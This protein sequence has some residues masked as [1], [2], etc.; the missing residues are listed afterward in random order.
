MM[1]RRTCLQQ[2]WHDSS[3]CSLDAGFRGWV[4]LLL[5]L[6]MLSST[7]CVK[8]RF[9]VTSFPEGA[10]V[11]VDNQPVGY[12]PVNVPFRYPGTREILL[13]KDGYKPIRIKQ[14]IRTP[15]YLYPPFSFITENFALREIRDQQAFDFQMQ[16]LNQVNDQDLIDR[17]ENLRGQVLRGAVTPSMQRQEYDWDE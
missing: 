9:L 5:A 4:L 12:T 6:L 11:T 2:C 1:T 7:G 8:R 15:W 3:R 17:A 16:P 10:A 14:A 13:E